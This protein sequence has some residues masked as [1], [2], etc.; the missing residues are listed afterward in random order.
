MAAVSLVLIAELVAGCRDERRKTNNDDDLDT[1]AGVIDVYQ[2]FE[3]TIFKITT[4]GLAAKDTAA[5]GANIPAVP[6][7]GDVMGTGTM[8]GTVAQSGS[9]NQNLNL[10]VQLNDYSDT[11]LVRYQTEGT[12]LQ[13]GLN[14][15]N[16]PSDNQMTGDLVG[17]LTLAGD[18]EGIGDFDLHTVSDLADDDANPALICTR[19]T[20]TV[21]AVHDSTLTVDFVIAAG[22]LD[23]AQALKCSTL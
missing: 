12:S 22:V 8:G 3:P 15:T 2:N 1:E 6:L 20:G 16:Q 13:F 5:Q 10:W 19:V 4:A 11:G 21:T 9:L 14:I 23:S 18:V 7:T 17:A